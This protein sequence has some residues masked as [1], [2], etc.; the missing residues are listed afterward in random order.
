MSIG[1]LPAPRDDDLARSLRG[2]FGDS[3]GF[4]DVVDSQEVLHEASLL[5]AGP[6]PGITT[7]VI[8]SPL[9]AADDMAQARRALVESDAAV[10]AL[11]SAVASKGPASSSASASASASGN[12][13]A[14][15]SASASAGAPTTSP[16][17][18]AATTAAAPA[19]PAGP[20]QQA[21]VAA[22]I[23]ST[24]DSS[25]YNTFSVASSA[26]EATFRSGFEYLHTMAAAARPGRAPHASQLPPTY[27]GR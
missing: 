10:Q 2:V 25:V 5:A 19:K 4:E 8:I 14:S 3:P 23:F 13:Q 1:L 20:Q 6:A 18:A 16:A 15:A 24:I 27:G 12:S 11:A 22:D 7:S 17:A 21:F 9:P 26:G